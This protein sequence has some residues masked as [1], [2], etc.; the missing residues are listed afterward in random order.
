MSSRNTVETSEASS[1]ITLYL[2]W[3]QVRS[4]LEGR[5]KIVVGMDMGKRDGERVR[6]KL[7]RTDSR[8][9]MR[10]GDEE[11][12]KEKKEWGQG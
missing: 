3:N 11:R 4:D 6:G 8:Q 9:R 10:D 2:I 12:E 5:V 1:C 7:E